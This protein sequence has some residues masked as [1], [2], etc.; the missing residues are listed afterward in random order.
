[1]STLSLDP[2]LY[3]ALEDAVGVLRNVA[4]YRME[5]EVD[6]RMHAI[7]ENKEACSRKEREEHR[8][9]AD[10]WR[11][12]TLQ[13]LQALNVLKRLHQ[14]APELVGDFPDPAAD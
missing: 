8:E 9:L 13:K 1:M 10:F 3:S 6:D 12:R 14:V 5:P 7:G 4:E 2:N 11:R